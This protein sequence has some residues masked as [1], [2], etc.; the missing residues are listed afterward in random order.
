MVAGTRPIGLGRLVTRV[1][2]P[3]DGTVRVEETRHPVRTD[4]LALPETHLSL[5]VSQ[6]V[7]EAC[8]GFLREGK[9]PVKLHD[10]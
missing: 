3:S 5:I 6:R 9:F 7:A 1:A 2:G 8:I 10:L 4:W